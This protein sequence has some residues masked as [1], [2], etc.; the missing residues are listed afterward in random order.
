MYKVKI[1]HSPIPSIEDVEDHVVLREKGHDFLTMSGG[2]HAFK[3]VVS[4][5]CLRN[6]HPY[7]PIPTAQVDERFGSRSNREIPV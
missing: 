4:R 1:L 7:K 6:M 5:H 2:A 3:D